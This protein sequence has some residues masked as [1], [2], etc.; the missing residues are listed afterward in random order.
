MLHLVLTSLSV[1]RPAWASRR[2]AVHGAALTAACAC[3]QSA[4]LAASP[5]NSP[6][7]AVFACSVAVHAAAS[8][9]AWL[10]G[11][12][13][14]KAAP[15]ALGS[16]E[17]CIVG[18]CIGSDAPLVVSFFPANAL[19]GVRAHYEQDDAVDHIHYLVPSIFRAGAAANSE[20]RFV[21]MDA[22]PDALRV[23]P[24]QGVMF[25]AHG[26]T[27]GFGLWA[28]RFTSEEADA[29]H[30]S[31][32]IISSVA[33]ELLPGSTDARV[34]GPGVLHAVR[35]PAEAATLAAQLSPDGDPRVREAINYGVLR[36]PLYALAATVMRDDS[37]YGA[38]ERTQATA[39]QV[40]LSRPFPSAPRGARH[41][42][43]S[44]GGGGGRSRILVCTASSSSDI[45]S[46]GHMPAFGLRRRHSIWAAA[47]A[48]AAVTQSP[49]RSVAAIASPATSTAAPSTAAT[50]AAA[51]TARRVVVFG[52]SGRTGRLIVAELMRAEALRRERLS[53][54]PTAGSAR[55][56]E[57]VAGVRSAAS[58]ERAR[59]Q[60]SA[61]GAGGGG[62]AVAGA[63][64]DV[65]IADLTDEGTP[66]AE[67]ASQLASLHVTDLVC[68]IGFSPSF[69]P[70]DD[71]R[72]AEAVDY[73]ATVRLIRA[74]ELAKLPGRFVLVSSLGVN[75][76]SSSSSA[77]LLDR[78]LGRVLQQKAAAEDA[79]RGTATLGWTIV[80]PGLLLQR[81]VSYGGVL[82]G[83]EDR[84]VGD[85]ER[86][87][88]DGYPG[89]LSCASPFLASSG[90]V[91]A[92]TRQQVAQVCVAA[93]L[94]A[95]SP[96]SEEDAIY[97]R[98]VV[99]VV[100]RPEV[101]K[102]SIRV[103]SSAS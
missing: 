58:A 95:D 15:E 25:G 93:I 66:I 28:Q 32:G 41:Q 47:G 31:M 1:V 22:S 80:R 94:A 84:W 49:T 73:R 43:A 21:T 9:D 20:R 46:S 38:A 81:Q 3:G 2:A 98:R 24:G 88:V 19:A 87:R 56:L 23:S 96:R 70:E 4:A 14:R 61:N 52:A 71:R 51:A 7:E 54:D 48:A 16:C 13:L 67:L 92:A 83:P 27:V 64:D 97:S 103:V 82:L 8:F 101:P 30:S 77:Q 35:S 18:R 85:P 44:A 50:A 36:P 86:D 78:S 63:A 45:V 60:L 99:E 37:S 11:V 57:V 55:A 5:V 17:R 100:A 34:P 6:P 62:G 68:A 59:A 89:A 69:L 74:A 72:L 42:A 91:C 40:R 102:G 26:L 79:L 12:Y 39:A 75:A 90:A 76:T 10:Q 65:L 33:G 29:E 53:E